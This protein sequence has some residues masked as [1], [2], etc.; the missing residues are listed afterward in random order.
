[1][2]YDVL[3]APGTD[4]DNYLLQGFCAWHDYATSS[5]GY[6]AFT[7][8]PYVM[9]AG[10]SCGQGFVNSPGTLDGYSIVNGHEYAET[11]TDMFPSAGWLTSSGSEVGDVCAWLSSGTGAAADVNLSTG[12]FAMQSTWS[13]DTGVCEIAHAIR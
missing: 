2:Q 10:A 7:N 5:F 11:V 9:D 1:V 4:P 12:S 13:N 3:S 8:M 6:L